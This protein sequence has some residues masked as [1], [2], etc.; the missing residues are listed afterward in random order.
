METMPEGLRGPTEPAGETSTVRKRNYTQRFDRMVFT[1]TTELPKIWRNGQVSNKYATVAHDT[2]QP[3]M[4]FIRKH[5]LGKR[6]HP[7]K[8]FEPFMPTKSKNK[9]D[10]S[11]ENCLKWTNVRALMEGAGLGGKYEDFVNFDL[12]EF[13]RH[14]GLYLLQALSPSPQIDMKFQCPNDDPVNGNEMVHKA[15][16]SSA[17]K[18]ERRHR[19][20]KSFFA[21]VDPTISIPSRTTHPNHKVSPLLRHMMTVS[22]EAIFLGQHLSCDEQTIGF[23]GTHKDKQ[24]ITYK[25]EGDG[26]LADCICSDGYTYSFYF[27]HQPPSPKIIQEFKCSPLH[28]RVIALINQLPHMSVNYAVLSTILSHIRQTCQKIGVGN[29]VEKNSCFLKI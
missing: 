6:S 18:A 11:I 20:F 13:K 17:W 19:H 25:K 2:T 12:K 1:G 16:G 14:L 7:S 21:S 8:W 23:Q 28:A 9:R 26:F 3:N 29:T 22:Q 15:F 10:F 4:A 5:G 27:R 24:R